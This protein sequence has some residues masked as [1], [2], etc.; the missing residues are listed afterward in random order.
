MEGK[1]IHEARRK[2]SDIDKKY[3]EGREKAATAHQAAVDAGFEGDTVDEADFETTVRRIM[4]ACMQG[5]TGCAGFRVFSTELEDMEETELQV[6]RAGAFV[7]EQGYKQIN[8]GLSCF[9][10]FSAQK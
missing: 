8:N 5:E 1:Q 9:Y 7:A 6:F 4:A 2:Q 3:Y 10:I